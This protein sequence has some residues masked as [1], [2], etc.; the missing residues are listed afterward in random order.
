[1]IYLDSNIFIIA[2]L[3]EKEEGQKARNILKLVGSKKRTFATSSLAFDEVLWVLIKEKSRTEAIMAVRAM[4]KIP[5]LRIINIEKNIITESINI[6][7]TTTL[8]PRDAIYLAA[9]RLKGVNEII[10]QDR[11]FDNIKGIRK[12]DINTFFRKFNE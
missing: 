2:A 3:E 6:I 8:K 11:D 5:Q 7:E 12:Y 1:M 10:T 4:L 9:M